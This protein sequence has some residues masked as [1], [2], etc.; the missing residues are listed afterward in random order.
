[1]LTSSQTFQNVYNAILSMKV[2]H[3]LNLKLLD[4]ED[5]V[6]YIL[7]DAHNKRNKTEEDEWGRKIMAYKTNSQWSGNFGENVVSDYLSIIGKKFERQ[8]EYKL[9]HTFKPDFTTDDELIEVKMSTY[10]TTGTA[11]EKILG[12]HIKYAEARKVLKKPLKVILLC[13]CE[14]YFKKVTTM[15]TQHYIDQFESEEYG[16]QFLFFSDMVRNLSCKHSNH[17]STYINTNV[18][19][20]KSILSFIEKKTMSDETHQATSYDI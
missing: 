18:G 8:K 17:S 15:Y 9:T 16:T 7:N 5:V 6:R 13:E 2:K 11:N 14:R 4:N 3:K 12:L 19:A 10:Y 1:M 20:Q